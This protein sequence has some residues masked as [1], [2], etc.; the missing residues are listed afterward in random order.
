MIYLNKGSS[1]LAIVRNIPV[2]KVIIELK[3]YNQDYPLVDGVD[4]SVSPR[5]PS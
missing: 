3:A 4:A 5:N 1:V 2:E